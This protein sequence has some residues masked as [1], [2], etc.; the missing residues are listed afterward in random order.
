MSI[1]AFLFLFLQ[2]YLLQN[3]LHPPQIKLLLSASE[4]EQVQNL[5]QEYEKRVIEARS[6][7][8]NEKML[9]V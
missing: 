3:D 6:K 2:H 8:I 4:I 5:S 9:Q 7:G 1:I